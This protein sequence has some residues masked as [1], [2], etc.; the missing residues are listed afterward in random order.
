MRGF[1]DLALTILLTVMLGP[2]FVYGQS[3]Q[4]T[5]QP[6]QESVQFLSVSIGLDDFLV[7]I[8]WLF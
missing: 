6:S 4:S 8:A 7:S 1:I 2:G 5:K 3:D